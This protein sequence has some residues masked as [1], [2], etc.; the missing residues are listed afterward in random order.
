MRII[1][2]VVKHLLDFQSFQWMEPFI[3]LQ[4]KSWCKNVWH[5]MV[6][7]QGKPKL[8]LVRINKV[9]CVAA[10]DHFFFNRL[11]HNEMLHVGCCNILIITYYYY[12]QLPGYFFTTRL[13]NSF[14]TSLILLF[15]DTSYLQ[16]VSFFRLTHVLIKSKMV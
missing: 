8:L 7:K 15:Q 3:L 10:M 4:E 6:V 12:L 16:N 1:H 2:F 14:L 13:D 11:F 5:W 9:W